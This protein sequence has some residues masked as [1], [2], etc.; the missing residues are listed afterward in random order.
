MCGK[1]RQGPRGG[2]VTLMRPP[3]P[4]ELKAAASLGTLD[5]V[6]EGKRP[7]PRRIPATLMT[8]YFDGL[9]RH[10]SKGVRFRSDCIRRDNAVQESSSCAAQMDGDG[11]LPRRP[12]QDTRPRSATGAS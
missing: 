9:E 5:P 7:E 8:A 4:V 12:L 6:F 1:S 10:T 11:A 2:T 3:L